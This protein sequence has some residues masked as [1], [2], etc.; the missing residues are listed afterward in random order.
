MPARSARGVQQGGCLDSRTV[1]KKAARHLSA[2]FL[3][4]FLVGLLAGCGTD[5]S[6]LLSS[7]T[8]EGLAAEIDRIETLVA[9]GDCFAALDRAEGSRVE[10]AALEGEIDERLR[11]S[12]L[13][14]LTQLQVVIQDECA[15]ETATD[16]VIEEEVVEEDS[17]GIR[18]RP[19]GQGDQNEEGNPRPAPDPEPTPS[20]TPAPTPT[21]TPPDSGGVTPGGVTPTPGGTSG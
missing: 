10:V 1:G 9:A 11:T 19:D 20:P 6:N 14:G 5:R 17:G 15:T 4:A 3:A 2:L 18:P 21:P 7:E 13:E 16:T 12:L 8:A